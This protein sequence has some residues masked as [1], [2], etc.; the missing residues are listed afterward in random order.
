MFKLLPIEASPS[1]WILADLDAAYGVVAVRCLSIQSKRPLIGSK[2]GVECERE[3]KQVTKYE[4][5]KPRAKLEPSH[6]VN[7]NPE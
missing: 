6:N 3:G 2:H 5:S 4:V 7:R 1:E